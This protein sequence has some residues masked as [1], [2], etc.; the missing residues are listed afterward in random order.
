[1]KFLKRLTI[2]ICWKAY[3]RKTVFS[4]SLFVFFLSFISLFLSWLLSSFLPIPLLRVPSSLS[5][6]IPNICK[7][8]STSLLDKIWVNIR[9]A[10]TDRI[11]ILTKRK[12]IGGM[13]YSP[14]ARNNKIV[15]KDE[16]NSGRIQNVLPSVQSIIRPA[17]IH[18]REIPKP[19]KKHPKG[20]VTKAARKDA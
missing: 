3:H 20:N 11:V 18:Q 10:F 4:Q 8:Q 19:Y 16:I 13:D 15:I 7:K 14:E 17:P 12:K 6:I 9:S 5:P 2:C 1:M